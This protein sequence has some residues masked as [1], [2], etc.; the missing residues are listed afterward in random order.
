MKKYKILLNAKFL[1]KEYVINK[2]STRQIAK[3]VGCGKGTITAYL[4]QHNIGIRTL[5]QAQKLAKPISYHYCVD[6]DKILNDGRCKRCRKCQDIKRAKM[7][8]GGGNPFYDK[9]HTKE[10]RKKL[11]LSH[12][13][14]GIPY[15]NKDYPAI[16]YR[17]RTK[18]RKRD[19]YICQICREYGKEV[20]HI[21]YDKENNDE[22]NL[23]TLCKTCH[24]KTNF[25][26]EYWTNYF[27]GGRIN[28]INIKRKIIIA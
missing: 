8:I 12:G 15:E 17:I 21:D 24:T 3:I 6:C 1:I 20:H 23:I 25:N 2:K 18:I 7:I 22:S 11:S 28:E 19:N 16:F 14:T 9:H 26:R 13:G 5:S 4:K 10:I 27:K